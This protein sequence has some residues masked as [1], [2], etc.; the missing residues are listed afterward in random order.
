MRFIVIFIIATKNLRHDLCA[1]SIKRMFPG[2]E[3]TMREFTGYKKGVNLGGWLSQCG[4]GNYTD[5]RFNNFITEDDFAKIASWGADHVR[6]PIDYNVIQNDDG[7]FIESGFAHIDRCIEWCKKYGLKMVL[8]LHKACG[9]VFD[10]KTYCQFFY[11]EELQDIFVRLWQELARRYAKYSAF[12]AF[13]LLNEITAKETAEIWNRIADRTIRA[14]RE[15]SADVRIII[16]GYF[17]SSIEGLLLLDKPAD[18]NI[19]F[20]FHCYSPMIFTHQSGYWVENMPSDYSIAYPGTVDE[21]RRESNAVFNKNYDNE[22]DYE[23]NLI[24]SSF[25]ERQFRTALDV[26]EKYNVPLYCGEYGVIDKADPESA[27]KWFA[28]IHAAMEKFNI[29]R[30]VWSFKEMDF[31]LVDEHYDGYLA[32]IVKYL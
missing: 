2:K 32:E 8:D 22:F 12:V 6:V 5:E 16:G 3:S 29:A 9:Y 21:Y 14:I 30:A 28:D 20:T 26:S 17:N 19:V 1:A 24:D 23:G 13:E 7:S 27:V 10:D 15:I 18:E 25:F 4:A 31:G 11:N